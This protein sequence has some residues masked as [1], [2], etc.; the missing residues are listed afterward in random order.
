MPRGLM[1]EVEVNAEAAPHAAARWRSSEL[2][3]AARLSVLVC[4]LALACAA[5]AAPPGRIISLAPHATEL[6]FAAGVG[7]QVVA[8]SESCD[9]PVEAKSL[10]RVSG[11]RGTNVEAVLALKPDRVVAWRGGNRTADL[12]ALRRF[13]ITVDES[14]IAT[15]PDIS[16]ELRRFSAWAR[17]DTD[18]EQA[19]ARADAFDQQL[20][21]L[22]ARYADKR[23]LRA[24]YQLGAGRLFTLSGRHYVTE[25]LAVC[26]AENVFASAPLPAPEITT[27]AVLS[28]KPD[29][30]IVADAAALVDARLFWTNVGLFADPSNHRRFITA[31]GARLHRPTLRTMEAIE[32]LCRQLDDLRQRVP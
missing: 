1:P 8:V 25:V 18:R 23:R 14:E 11:Y 16:R 31:D 7:S 3:I 10:P 29:V 2:R 27:E 12:D 32:M 26:G 17:R 30:V 13:G 15:L 6:L 4:A 19:L 22:R 28:V 20:A 9:Y 21:A 5:G 24:F